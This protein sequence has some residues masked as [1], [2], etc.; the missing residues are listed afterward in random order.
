MIGEGYRILQELTLNDSYSPN[1][2]NW[3][4]SV[5]PIYCPQCGKELKPHICG[6]D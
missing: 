6:E 2:V 1:V 4:E 3:Y 5:V